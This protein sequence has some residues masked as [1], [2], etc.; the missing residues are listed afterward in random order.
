MTLQRRDSTVIGEV[1][2]ARVSTCRDRDSR[3][4]ELRR[5]PSGKPWQMAPVRARQ[6]AQLL[7]D[8]ADASDQV[9]KSEQ[10]R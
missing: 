5:L 2:R 4:I 3:W 1:H 9:E 7:M 8:A 10:E 6:I